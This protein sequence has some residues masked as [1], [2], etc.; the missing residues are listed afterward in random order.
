MP[1]TEHWTT[2]GDVKLFLWN[3]AQ[4]RSGQD[5][6]TILFV[7]GS[8]MASQPTFDLQVPG[9]PD[10]SVMDWFAARRATTPGA[11]TWRATA[12]PTKD[13]DINCADLLRRR[14]LLTPPRPSSPKLRGAAPAPRLRH[15]V[16]RA[17]RGDVRRAP[18]RAG[19]APCLD[20]LV[21]TGEGW[22]TLAERRK[23]LPEFQARTA[24]RSTA[25]SCTRSSTAT[26]RAPPSGA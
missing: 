5:R 14:R 10:S 7:H 9:R 6:G 16:G 12:A 25:P 26:I 22:L 15:F 3:K 13:R 8:S 24:A 2:K 4:G 18:S 11:S 17:A 19:R 23:K 21:W 20:A 1:G